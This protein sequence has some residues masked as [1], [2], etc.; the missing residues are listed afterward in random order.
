MN[1]KRWRKAAALAV[2]G[3]RAPQPVAAWAGTLA[4]HDFAPRLSA[5]H[6]GRLE[7]VL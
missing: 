5:A 7:R 2:I 4:A 6:T 3:R 1:T